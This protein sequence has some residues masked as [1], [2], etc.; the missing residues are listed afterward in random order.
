MVSYSVKCTCSE[1]F[2]KRFC[3]YFKF[4]LTQL[5][6]ISCKIKGFMVTI[7]QTDR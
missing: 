6:V 1:P 2:F 3:K 4:Q 5:P 7:K